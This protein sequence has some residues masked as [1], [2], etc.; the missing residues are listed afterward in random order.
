MYTVIVASKQNVYVVFKV[1]S[2]DSYD[3]FNLTFEE[4]DWW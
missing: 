2:E 1:L 4:S 3:L